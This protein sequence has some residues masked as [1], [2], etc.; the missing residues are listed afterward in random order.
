MNASSIFPRIPRCSLASTPARPLGAWIAL[1]V[2]LNIFFC[3][4]GGYGGDIG[5]WV[6]WTTQLQSAGYAQLDANYPPVYIHWLW[7]IAKLDAA[8]N[9]SVAQDMLLRFLTNTPVLLAHVATVLVCDRLLARSQGLNDRRWNLIIGFVALNPAILMNGPLWG[10]VDLL[11]SLMLVISLFLLIEA[12]CLALVFPVL[13]LA[14]L[15]KFQSICIAPVVLPLLWH[16]RCRALW[17]GILPAA[18]LAVMLLL[19]YLLAGNTSRMLELTYLKAASMYPYASYHANNLWYLLGLNERPDSLYVFNQLNPVEPWQKWL[20]PKT[21]G[22]LLCS[23]WGVL[24]MVSSWRRDENALHWRNAFLAA[25]GFFIFLPAMHERYMMPAAILALAAAAR[26]FRFRFHAIALTV[27]CAGNMLFVL[28]PNGG[29]LSYLFSALTL[30]LAVIALMPREWPAQLSALNKLSLGA[31][32][33]A[34]CAFWALAFAWHLQ[35]ALPPSFKESLDA[36]RINTRSVVQGWGSLR[37]GASVGNNAM[38]VNGR[39]FRYGFGTHAPSTITLL[40]PADAQS[41]S[42][43]VGVDDESGGAELEFMVR[44]DGIEVWRSGTMRNH[45]GPRAVSISVRNGHSLELVVDSLGAD[46][47]DHADWIEPRFSLKQ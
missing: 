43:Q 33:L 14:L 32:S 45:E 3:T 13:T 10:Q 35:G 7:L 29:V 19:P 17:L 5:Y 2:L 41:F 24:M 11:F 18:V 6:N 36:T 46:T 4:T 39:Q 1:I 30:L 40:V 44:L 25:L 9:I 12:R 15:T 26:H 42:A 20:T 21:L 31:W 16:R 47:G 8:L 38:V 23:A 27:L 37:V 34:A 28:H 22:M